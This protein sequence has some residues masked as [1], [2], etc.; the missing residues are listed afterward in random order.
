MG[1]SETGFLLHYALVKICK[2]NKKELGRKLKLADSHDIYRLLRQYDD[3]KASLIATN[4][5]LRLFME[6]G[7]SIDDALREYLGDDRA[8]IVAERCSCKHEAYVQQALAC[9][10]RM[11][12]KLDE[13]EATSEVAQRAHS[14][15][16]MLQDE[17]CT[18]GKDSGTR[19]RFCML[20]DRP[21]CP[22]FEF[23]KFVYWL[24]ETYFEGR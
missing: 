8:V 3:G 23:A 10:H 15:M 7:F 13:V 16:L 20:S 22:C 24:G 2:G 6:A 5:V 18:K 17:Y 11:Q 1:G 14:F 12:K 19:C 9:C 21:R 4:A